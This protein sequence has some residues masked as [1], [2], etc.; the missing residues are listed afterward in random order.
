MTIKIF[1]LNYSHQNI[2]TKTNSIVY[3][4]SKQKVNLKMWGY[5]A[6]KSAIWQQGR[7]MIVHS[8]SGPP[9]NVDIPSADSHAF[10]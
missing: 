7:R 4:L 6:E 9:S 3:L 10:S 2:V 1:P 5:L 8:L